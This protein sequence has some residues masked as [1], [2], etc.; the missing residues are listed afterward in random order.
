VGIL[1]IQIH[2]A[3]RTPAGRVATWDQFVRLKSAKAECCCQNC[4]TCVSSNEHT[5]TSLRL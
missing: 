4:C 3:I 1:T 5:E 2:R